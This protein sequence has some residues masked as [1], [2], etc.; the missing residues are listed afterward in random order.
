[1]VDIYMQL[2]YE[3]RHDTC[4]PILTDQPLGSKGE[5]SKEP[6]SEWGSVPVQLKKKKYI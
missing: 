3:Y 2:I 1:M 6:H 5:R 4:H